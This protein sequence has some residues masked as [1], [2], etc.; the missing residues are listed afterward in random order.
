MKKRGVVAII[1]ACIS[2][3]VIIAGGPIYKRCIRGPKT[4]D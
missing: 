4:E 1:I 2:L 3:I